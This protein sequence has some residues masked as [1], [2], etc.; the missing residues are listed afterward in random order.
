[1]FAKIH[2][3][4]TA[5]GKSIKMKIRLLTFVTILANILV[6]SVVKYYN[7]FIQSFIDVFKAFG[8]NL[9]LSTLRIILPI[10]ISFYT[11]SALSYVL[12]IYKSKIHPS[13]NVLSFFAYVSFFPSLLSGP[14]GRASKQLPQFFIKR[15]FNYAIAVEGSKM[16]LWGL[17]M[18]LCVANRLG[19]YVDAIYNNS[20]LHN[21]TSLLLAT[22]LYAFQL[23]CDF[24]GYSLIAIGIGRLLGFTLNDNF[25]RPYFSTSYSDYWKRNHISLTQWLIDYIYFP[26]IGKS[27]KLYFWNLC[28]ILTFIVSGLWHGAGWTF[29]FWGLYQGIFI[30]ISTNNS[31]RRKRIEKKYQLKK[32]GLYLAITILGTFL[33]IT[34]GLVFFRASSLK[35]ALIIFRNIFTHQGPLFI[36]KPTFF[37]AAICLFVLVLKDLRDEFFPSKLKLF[38]NKNILI[39]FAS[40]AIIFLIILLCGVFDGGQFIYFQF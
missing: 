35:D 16:I 29:I 11:F 32:N 18:K 40:Y 13:K 36:D 1:M 23:Y 30:V 26:L 21:G 20:S 22:I 27:D 4:A 34:L 28:M 37:Y 31:R 10:G 9:N 15:V 39:R 38:E 24:G 6:L 2:N 25:L 7:F 19:L 3:T 5:I 17:F 14:I 33:I 8:M 12:D